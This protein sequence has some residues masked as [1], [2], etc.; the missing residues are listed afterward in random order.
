[1]KREST[2]RTVLYG[3]AVIGMGFTLVLVLGLAA[4]YAAFDPTS[5]GYEPPY[6]DYSGEPIDWESE[7]YTTQKGMVKPGYVMDVHLDCT[8]GM[9]SFDV[10]NGLR[11]DFRPLSDRAI[12]IHEPREACQDRG[13]HPDF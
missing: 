11:V 5:G 8:T 3:F 13:F 9:L 12:A 7:A 2:V 1:M 4:D 10:V 6:D